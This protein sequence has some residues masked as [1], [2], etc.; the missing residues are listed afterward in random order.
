MDAKIRD[1][2]VNLCTLDLVS[3]LLGGEVR[4]A[5]FERYWY[6]DFDSQQ[7]LPAESQMNHA[8]I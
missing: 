5:I 1:I 7:F 4:Q 6:L 2:Y 8:L 3:D